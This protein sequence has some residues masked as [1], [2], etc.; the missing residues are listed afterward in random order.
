M[1]LPFTRS[2]AALAVAA[3]CASAL[4]AGLIPSYASSQS[5]NPVVVTATRT[6]TT[7]D[8]AL[9]DITVIDAQSIRDAGAATLPELLRS[10]G[11][12]EISQTGGAGS[13]SGLFVR[14]TRNS[15]SI[16][17]VDGIRIE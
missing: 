16:V 12:I 4:A 10:A 13:V 11:G 1:F 14:G 9:A 3:R 5:M 2:A 15:Q 6:E 8:R 17:L 7:I